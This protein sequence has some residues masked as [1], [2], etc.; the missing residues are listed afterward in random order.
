VSIRAKL[1]FASTILIGTIIILFSHIQRINLQNTFDQI[2]TKRQIDIKKTMYDE[3]TAMIE[4]LAKTLRVPILQN[5]FLSLKT[6]V[7]NVG[8]KNKRIS[9]VIVSDELGLIVGHTN[10]SKVGQYATGLLKNYISVK[11]LKC[12]PQATIEG[13]KSIVFINPI[14]QN[15]K[16]LGTI[17]LA[18]SLLPLEMEMQGVKA[19]RDKMLQKSLQT[20]SILGILG[21]TIGIVFAVLQAY[22]ISKPI[23]EVA[24][25]ADQ[26]AKGD[27]HARV[28]VHT[29]DEIG[30]LGRRFNFMAEQALI[31]I[32][33]IKTKAKLEAE[34]AEL[35]R[36]NKMMKQ[37]LLMAKELQELMIPHMFPGE[38]LFRVQAKYIPIEEVGG[39]FFDL[40]QIDQYRFGIL[41][42]DVCGHGV[43]AAMVTAMVKTVFAEKA[44]FNYSSHE[45][46]KM[47][48]KEL[49]KV[50]K[51][52]S[53]LT[54][55]YAILDVS[56]GKLEYTC[57]GHPD[58]L[59]CKV[60]SAQIHRLC[61]NSFYVGFNENETFKSDV[62]ELEIGDRLLFYTDGII[63]AKDK[64][65][66]FYNYDSLMNVAQKNRS[67]DLKCMVEAIVDD[68]KSFTRDAILVDDVALLAIEINA[69]LKEEKDQS[70]ITH[71]KKGFDMENNIRM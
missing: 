2:L 37:E 16:G 28:N 35:A 48:N 31:Y 50:I 62:V 34:K 3:A 1:I 70:M 53:Y 55:I 11:S 46:V 61:T 7:K 26:I 69:F 44:R 13:I 10:D 30:D 43:A 40:F 33:E 39:D 49:C 12:I 6:V 24:K 18:M 38:N 63:E 17:L 27:L 68:L 66:N 67:V 29:N 56:N 9:A 45:T 71:D 8:E 15:S 59:I 58:A 21:L 19:Q 4:L 47:A 25:Q 57:A 32:E 41:I 60:N 51:N 52:M 64:N 14:A 22:K 54:S 65:E 5:D 23:K 20:T 42:V 36:K